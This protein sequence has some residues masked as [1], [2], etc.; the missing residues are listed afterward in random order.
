[1][2]W[3]WDEAVDPDFCDYVLSKCDWKKAQEGKVNEGSLKPEARITNLIWKELNDPITA[4][5]RQ[6][7]TFA[8]EAAGWSFD[9]RQTQPTQIGQYEPGGHYTWHVD[10]YPPDEHGFQRKLSCSILLNDHS[11]YEGGDLEI[12][13]TKNEG[14]PRKKGSIIVFPSILRHRVT[15]VTSGVRYSA[16]CWAMGP[17]FK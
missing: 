7:M 3:V 8:N 1:M 9:V 4:V 10:S 17:A 6:Y 11:E 16:V 2:Y 13:G 5:A 14:M 12:E 15:P